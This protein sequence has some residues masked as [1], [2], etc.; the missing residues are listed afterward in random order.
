MKALVWG[1]DRPGFES[2]PHHSSRVILGNTLS[3]LEPLFSHL[4]VE[5]SLPHRASLRLEG[6]GG[7]RCVA[8]SQDLGS[9]GALPLRWVSGV[10]P[11]FQDLPVTPLLPL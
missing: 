8:L 3:F 7:G 6:D 9:R 11:P 5:T 4:C 10:G 1:P 2:W